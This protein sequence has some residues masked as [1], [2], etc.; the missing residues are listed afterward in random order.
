MGNR[1]IDLY[2]DDPGAFCALLKGR[3][4]CILKSVPVEFAEIL[5]AKKRKTKDADGS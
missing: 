4:M 1:V 3:G 5:V 2:P